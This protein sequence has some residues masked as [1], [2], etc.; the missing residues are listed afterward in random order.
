LGIDDNRLSVQVVNDY[1]GEY[2][3]A[4]PGDAPYGQ[5]EV[6]TALNRST[7]EVDVRGRVALPSSHRRITDSEDDRYA[8]SLT[9][10]S[11]PLRGASNEVELILADAAPPSANVRFH[12]RG[13]TGGVTHLSEAVSVGGVTFFGGAA[14][15]AARWAQRVGVDPGAAAS[16]AVTGRSMPRP[17][18]TPEPDPKVAIDPSP[19]PSGHSVPLLNH[20]AGYVWSRADRVG[21][22]GTLVVP[23][24]AS[25]H[26]FEGREG[27]RIGPLPWRHDAQVSMGPDQV[28]RIV[29]VSDD[30]A[31]VERGTGRKIKGEMWADSSRAN[32]DTE[33]GLETLQW[34][35]VVAVDA[36]LPPRYPPPPPP[37]EPPPEEEEEDEE[38]REDDDTEPE[39]GGGRGAGKR[40][41]QLRRK[42]GVPKR[43][44]EW[45]LVG[46]AGI[47]DLPPVKDPAGQARDLSGPGVP[48]P[49]KTAGVRVKGDDEG[50]DLIRVPGGYVQWHGFPAVTPVGDGLVVGGVEHPLRREPEARVG[51]AP[52]SPFKP[53]GGAGRRKKP[54]GV[55]VLPPLGG[56]RGVPRGYGE[57]YDRARRVWHRN[58]A[59][60]E[61]IRE[62]EEIE[63]RARNA[64]RERYA[65]RVG[66]ARA[67]LEKRRQEREERIERRRQYRERKR[68]EAA[69]RKRKREERFS[70]RR[71]QARLR[72][73]R[74]QERRR[75]REQRKRP[76]TPQGGYL[77]DLRN[78]DLASLTPEQRRLLEEDVARGWLDPKVLGLESEASPPRAMGEW[79]V[80]N[81]PLPF[82]G[83][84]GSL[85]QWA[86][87]ATYQLRALQ[88]IL[89]G[90]F[91]GPDY[92]ASNLALKDVSGT[93]HLLAGCGSK[94]VLTVRACGGVALCV[95]GDLIVKGRITEQ[96]P[97]SQEPEARGFGRE[98]ASSREV[99]PLG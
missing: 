98:E 32:K 96:G 21:L 18:A 11:V 3:D 28:G 2:A 91:G 94:P 62:L 45:I 7:R 71:R 27:T 57:R 4:R 79:N 33:L 35:P 15:E 78:P 76:S 60:E 95:E 99:E 50:F 59:E 30:A 92:L 54:T 85:E 23:E 74:R 47:F 40:R 93:G 14:A 64:G 42:A 52:V 1:G 46:G 22:L 53:A 75:Q 72:R 12:E 38:E 10:R 61:R 43:P 36:D 25:G 24:G 86:N 44:K 89:L 80:A 68:E 65:D 83:Q 9:C 82:L 67:R 41:R 8:L 48:C 29:F 81:A 88:R 5:P 39:G 84:V 20:P 16:A 66:R 58:R 73:E 6:F 70:E 51:D 19:D 69:E 49:N 34:R 17:P 90:A 56:D 87:V 77:I 63:R 13:S 97:R 37:W 26:Y 31:S 55:V